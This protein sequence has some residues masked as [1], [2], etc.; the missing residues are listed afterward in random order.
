MIPI[1]QR[2]AFECCHV[3]KE[4]K[5]G[6]HSRCKKYKAARKKYDA[7]ATRIKQDKLCVRG[8]RNGH[9]SAG[10]FSS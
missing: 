9:K 6:C 2:N 7:L 4:R 5:P 1:M 3:C 8:E 10:G